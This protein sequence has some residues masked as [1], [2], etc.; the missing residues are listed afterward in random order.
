MWSSGDSLGAPV[1]VQ[2][3][4]RQLKRSRLFDLT[5]RSR[6]E[7]TV[8]AG[9]FSQLAPDIWLGGVSA[10]RGVSD[11]DGNSF[12]RTEGEGNRA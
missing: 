7:K 3:E 1:A 12:E 11:L 10:I 4:C 6:F 2:M 8:G 9:A 5:A